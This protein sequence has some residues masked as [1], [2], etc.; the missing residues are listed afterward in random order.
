M[1]HNSRRTRQQA[2]NE[3][4]QPKILAELAKNRDKLTRKYV[5]SNPN[6]PI[7]SLE[8]LGKEFPERIIANPIFNLLLL[9]NP[10]SY[11]VRLCLARSLTTAKE[12]L[13]KLA[14]FE[15]ITVKDIKIIYAIARPQNTPIIILEKLLNWYPDFYFLYSSGI[16][17]WTITDRIACLIAKNQK[18]PSYLLTKIAEERSN[19]IHRRLPSNKIYP[20]TRERLRNSIDFKIFIAIASH[21]NTSSE[22]LEYLAVENCPLIHQILLKHPNVSLKAVDLVRFRQGKLKK[23]PYFLEELALDKRAEVRAFVASYPDTPIS[24]VQLLTKDR[25]LLVLLAIVRKPNIPTIILEELAKQSNKEIHKAIL[26]HPNVSD[27][28]KEIIKPPAIAIANQNPRFYFRR[29]S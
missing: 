14:D 7:E 27:K 24:S 17:H 8:I 12:T 21:Q 23:T 2:R 4:T 15:Q 18:T 9:E 22:I 3:K 11:F 19:N 16:S 25:A 10:S 6:T 28:A 5:A 13:I 20:Q 29:I 1:S 26:K